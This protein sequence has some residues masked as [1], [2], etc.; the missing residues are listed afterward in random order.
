[1]PWRCEGVLG[2]L[3]G[4]SV[5]KLKEAA[6]YWARGSSSD[7]SHA[8]A[9]VLGLNADDLP[10]STPED[11][12]VLEENWEIVMMFMRLQTQWQVT[13]GGFVGLRY[14]TLPW[15]CGLY[16]VE[17]PRTMLEGIQVMEAA[18]LQKLNDRS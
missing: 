4:C 5:K 7:E 13:M 11:F 9:A 14:E 15:L 8:D 3:G 12:E 2:I 17:E 6:E 10:S 1:M 18:A 16:S